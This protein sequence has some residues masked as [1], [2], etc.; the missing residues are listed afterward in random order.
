MHLL[1]ALFLEQKRWSAKKSGTENQHLKKNFLV[2]LFDLNL[3]GTDL[4]MDEPS[5][6]KKSHT[7]KAINAKGKV[8]AKKGSFPRPY[9]E[10][11]S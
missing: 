6:A 9:R 3:L 4:M 7:T 8:V 1:W 5:R 11:A 2:L 10:R